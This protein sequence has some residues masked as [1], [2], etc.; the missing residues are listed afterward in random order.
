[1]GNLIEGLI[2][3]SPG[4][5]KETEGQEDLAY[6]QKGTPHAKFPERPRIFEI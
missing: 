4:Q 2:F 5:G 6:Y 1:L 3:A